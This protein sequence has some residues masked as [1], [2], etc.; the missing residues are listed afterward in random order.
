MI[1]WALAAKFI[2]FEC[3]RACTGDGPAPVQVVAWCFRGWTNVYSDVCRHML[4]LGLNELRFWAMNQKSC[5]FAG[6][7]FKYF[8]LKFSYFDSNFLSVPAK[9]FNKKWSALVQIMTCCSEVF[10]PYLIQCCPRPLMPSGIAM[11][12]WINTSGIWSL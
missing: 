4:S 10:S 11:S 7:I 5:Q 12:Q 8:F 2:S 9:E 6:N 3:H 1:S